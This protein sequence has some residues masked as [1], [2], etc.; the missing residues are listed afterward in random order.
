MLHLVFTLV[1]L[2]LAASVSPVMLSEQTVLLAGPQGRRSGIAY[3]AGT[4]TV[5][6]AVVAAVLAMGRS[7]SLPAAPHLDATL[8]LWIGAGLLVL[9]GALHRGP[10]G[11]RERR[12]AALAP[13][14]AYAFGLFSMATNFTTLALVVPATKDVASAH[15]GA[16]ATVLAA[17]LPVALACLPAWG[18]VA[19]VGAAPA[20]ADRVLGW[21]ERQ[22]E[23]C[24]RLALEIILA[25]AGVFLLLR[26]VYGLSR[27]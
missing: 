23:R 27:L 19:L 9:A 24:G 5:A 3:A 8:D 1:P 7:L 6:V 25:G 13:P 17:S 22:I 26:G 18:P 15:L 16:A 2:G 10:R 4:A 11:H 21:L 14:A 20:V 12:R